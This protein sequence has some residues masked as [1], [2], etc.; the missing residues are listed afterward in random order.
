MRKE[1][2]DAARL[3]HFKTLL[4]KIRSRVAGEYTQM[5]EKMPD[6]A[7]ATGDVSAAPTHIGDMDSE[8]LDAEIELIHNEEDMVKQ[9]DDA[10]MR[11]E[12]KTFGTCEECGKAIAVDRLEAIPYTA[13]CIECARKSNGER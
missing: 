5:V 13:F 1:F 12:N 7:I 6:R 10:L 2:M 3:Q 4:Q 11:I 8:V 9:I